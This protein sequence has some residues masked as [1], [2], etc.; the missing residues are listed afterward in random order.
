MRWATPWRPMWN[1]RRACGWHWRTAWIPLSTAPSPMRISCGC[2]G[3]GGR[4]CVP[5]SPRPCP[6]RCL[7]GPS[8][9]PRRWSSTTATW[10]SRAS[11]TAPRRRWSRISRWCWA[12]TWAARG[13]PST[14]SGGS[15]T[16]STS[17]WG[18]PTPSLCTPPPAAA[19]SWRVSVGRPARWNR[20]R[21]RTSSLRRRIHW[22][23]YGRCAM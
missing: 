18:C 1:H 2:S 23:T 15:C 14:T 16:T 7:T 21:R 17:M 12:T 3:S 10:C 6:M 20:E 8:P 19:P 5:P 9:T 22:P 13:S 4:F 11:S